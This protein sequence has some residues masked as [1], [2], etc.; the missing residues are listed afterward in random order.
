MS[1]VTS[2]AGYSFGHQL[3]VR[4]LPPSWGLGTQ[5]W[6]GPEPHSEKSPLLTDCQY[7]MPALMGHAPGQPHSGHRLS[8]HPELGAV[9]GAEVRREDVRHVP[10]GVTQTSKA[11]IFTYA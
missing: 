4:E 10:V 6:M 8:A 1:L 7:P 11:I 9:P 5:D 3:S 2:Q